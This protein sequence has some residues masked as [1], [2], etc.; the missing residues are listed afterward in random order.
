MGAMRVRTTEEVEATYRRGLGNR[1]ALPAKG[2][3]LKTDEQ[4]ISWLVGLGTAISAWERRWLA[5]L[6]AAA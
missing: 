5:R 3:A 6:R 1:N 4:I 2:S